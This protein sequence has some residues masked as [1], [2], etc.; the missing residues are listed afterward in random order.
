ME[1][2]ELKI[3]LNRILDMNLHNILYFKMVM[4]EQY[5]SP[6]RVV[7]VVANADDL[8]GRKLAK[9]VL[10][11]FNWQEFK[12]RGGEPL[13]IGLANRFSVKKKVKKINPQAASELDDILQIPVVV[14]D[15]QSV[16]IFSI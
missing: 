11:G 2:E 10:P 12:S 6:C 5:L 3:E 13:A 4:E 16:E 9:L 1:T 15:K 7:I 8:F 14:A